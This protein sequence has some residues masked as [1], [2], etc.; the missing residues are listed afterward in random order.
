M[1]EKL[2]TLGSHTFDGVTCQLGLMDIPDLDATLASVDR[3]L[4][5]GGWFV[6]VIAHPCI[7]VPEAKPTARPDRPRRRRGH[8]LLRRA[9]L[10]LQQSTRRPPHG[11]PTTERSAPISTPS[12]A[13]VSRSNV[14][15]SPW[16]RVSSRPSNRSTEKS[17]CSLPLAPARNDPADSRARSRRVRCRSDRLVRASWS[18][19][20]TTSGVVPDPN[21]I[22]DRS[23]RKGTTDGRQ[24]QGRF[25][26]CRGAVSFV[27][28]RWVKRDKRDSPTRHL[29]VRPPRSSAA[30]LPRKAGSETAGRHV[31]RPLGGWPTGRQ[32]Y[33]R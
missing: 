7:L 20:R 24:R 31:R 5:P 12:P 14:R 3:V 19:T 21:Q 15:T 4:E 30:T 22:A 16:H 13:P 17:P 23:V 32:R 28:R 2:A 10:A 29:L 27:S 18:S 8:G 11:G 9:V 33:L 25:R 6:F 1:L 26:G